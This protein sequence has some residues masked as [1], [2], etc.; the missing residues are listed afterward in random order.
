M[1]SAGRNGSP[2][3]ACLFNGLATG[4][5]NGANI[6]LI[7]KSAG[8]GETGRVLFIR[9]GHFWACGTFPASTLKRHLL[10]FRR[11]NDGRPEVD[12]ALK[13]NVLAVLAAFVFVG[14]ILLG[15]F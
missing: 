6:F 4:S 12:Y 2:R 10:D 7:E 3:N 8:W 11:G 5:A 1:L 14:A 9:V 15:A 13:L